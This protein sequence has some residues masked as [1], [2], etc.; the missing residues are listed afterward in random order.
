MPH[1]SRCSRVVRVAGL[2]AFTALL[3]ASAPSRAADGFAVA[4]FL[5][6]LHATDATVRFELAEEASA[7][8]ELTPASGA[9]RRFDSAKPSRFHSVHLNG[10]KPATTLSYL[11]RTGA[12]TSEQGTFTTAPDDNRPFTFTLYGDSRTDSAA[13]ASVV[14]GIEAMAS[15]FLIGT[16]DIVDYGSNRGAWLEFFSIERRL[17]RDRCLFSVVG[18]HELVGRSR[19]T[20]MQYLTPGSQAGPS[21]YTFRWSNAR[22]FMLDAMDPWDG[23]QAQWLRNELSKA[24]SE[25]GLQHRFVVMH[26]SPFSSGPHGPNR[27]FLREGMV[28]LL[29]TQRVDLLMAG[30]DHIYERGEMDGLKY[31]VSGGAGAPLY[32]IERKLP[33]AVAESTH[34]FV[35][36]HV[37]GAAVDIAVHVPGKGVLERSSY[38]TG[39]PW[40]QAPPASAIAA[41]GSASSPAAPPRPPAST[42]PATPPPQPQKSSRCTCS[43][44]GRGQRAPFVALVVAAALAAGAFRHRD[45]RP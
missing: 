3:L 41:S 32:P 13:H 31:I 29:A 26:H 33:G 43:A 24:S 45:R 28:N 1:V 21:Y 44:P 22:F 30:H 8:V 6:D 42:E 40:M 37:D 25:A 17:L 39:H 16:G 14:R 20:W 18:N 19:A 7:V 9:P 34:H 23:E 35:Q 38:V 4:P 5:Q 36:V 27:A 2:C 15:D 12:L 10:L 11:V